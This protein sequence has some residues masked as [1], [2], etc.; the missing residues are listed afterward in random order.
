MLERGL[1]AHQQILVAR[2]VGARIE[3][4]LL[5]RHRRLHCASTERRIE[6]D[7]LHHCYIV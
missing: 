1:L 7:L 5:V 3:R 4:V 2:G 6:A